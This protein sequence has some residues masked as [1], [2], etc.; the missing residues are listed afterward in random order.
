MCTHSPVRCDKSWVSIV[1][2][3]VLE[4]DQE[5]SL[6]QDKVTQI[7]LA[8]KSSPHADLSSLALDKHPLHGK[9]VLDMEKGTATYIPEPR[10]VGDDEFIYKL[11]T[12]KF[13]C[14]TATGTC[15]RL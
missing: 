1:V 7:D 14:A 2:R 10:Y 12:D 3:L 15:P 5:I 11:C 8:K 13:N 9:V 6:S 4:Q